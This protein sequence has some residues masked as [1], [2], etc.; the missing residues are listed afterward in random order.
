M[1]FVVK[2]CRVYAACGVLQTPNY[3]Y[4]WEVHMKRKSQKFRRFI[5]SAN[6]VNYRENAVIIDHF[7][8]SI[9]LFKRFQDIV[10]AGD[11]EL[12]AEKLRNAGT[13]L[14]QTCEW[15][16]KNYLH[17]RYVELGSD[18]TLNAEQKTQKIDAL[19]KKD[20]T[21][22][23][24]IEEFKKISKPSYK[25]CGINFNDILG[26]AQLTNN[27]P[28]HN[29]TIPDPNKYIKS[30][31]EVRKIISNYIDGDAKL[32]LI[33][34]SIYGEGNAWYEVLEYTSDFSDAYSY[35]LVTRSIENIDVKG[36]FSLKWDLILDLDPA[37]DISGLE[38]MYVDN[39]GATPWIRILDKIDS[40]K[41]FSMS[42][43]P[44]WIMG[45]GSVDN[46][47][48]IAEESKWR[49]RYGKYLNGVLEEFHKIYTK[50]VKVFV[51]PMSNERN[52][53]RIVECFDDIYDEGETVDFCV[54]SSQ[55]EYSRIDN[56]NFKISS[57]SFEEFCNN[58]RIFFENDIYLHGMINHQL[59]GEAGKL[60]DIPDAFDM[61]LQDSFEV[62]YINVETTEEN[63]V[64][65]TVKSYFYRGDCDISWY[66]LKNGFDVIR[67]EQ[68]SIIEKINRD[69][70]DRGRYLKRICYEPGV[71]GTTLMRRLAWELRAQYPTL[72][73]KKYNEQ[74]ARNIQKLYDITHGQILIFADSNNIEIEEIK[75]LQFELKRMGFAF[76][77]CYM[78]RKL[79]GLPVSDAAIYTI[80]KSFI[81]PEAIE[82]K[83]R[84]IEYTSDVDVKSKLNDII[85]KNNSDERIPFIMS[86]YTFDKEFKGIKPYIS[87]YLTHM[88]NYLKKMV[89][90]LALA[91]YGN[92]SIDMQYFMDLFEDDNTADFIV[93]KIPGINELIRIE[94]INGKDSIRIRYHLFAEEILK[95]MSL[96]R[97]ANAISFLNLVD[98]ILEFIEDSRKNKFN[99]NQDT[100]RL[101]RTLF[102]TRSA[103][104]DAEKPAFSPLITK[105][106]E[107]HRTVHNGQ[108]SEE[109]DA[110]IRIFNKLVEVYPEEA[111]FTAHLAR[112]YFY[113]DRN[114]KKGFDNINYAIKLSD[115]MY[116]YVD[117]LLFH[118]KAMGYSSKICNEYIHKVMENCRQGNKEENCKLLI[119]IEEDATKAFE[120]FKKVRQSNIGIA[121]HVSEINLCISIAKMA[122]DVLE[123]TENFEQYILSDTGKWVMRYIDKATCL[124]EE[125]RKIAPET[126]DNNLEEIETKI[127]DLKVGLEESISLWEDY[128]KQCNGN[129]KLQAR[130]LL[131]G[132]YNKQSKKNISYEEKQKC[133]TRIIELMEDNMTEENNHSGNI[134]IWFDTIRKCDVG[135][136]DTLL[137]DAIIKLN[138]WIA[139]TDSVEAHYYRFIL[140]FIQA[141]NGSA[142]AESELP[143]L[144]RELKAKSLNL[145]NRTATQ[146]WLMSEGEG[147]GKLMNNSRNKKEALSEEEMAEKM[148]LLV[149]RISNNYVNDSH[150]Y[151][152]FRGV[153]VYFNP[154]ATKGEIDRTKINQRVRFGIGFSYDGP[155]AFNSSIKL[156]G[157]DDYEEIER[158]IEPGLVVKCE[159]IKNVVYFT[160]VRII[161]YNSHIGSIHISELIA[162]YSNT[163][164]PKIGDII[165]AKVLNEKFD[166]R[167]QR[168]VWM[169]TMDMSNSRIETEENETVMAKAIKNLNLDLNCK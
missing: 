24:L 84:L 124:W 94:N 73:L 39:V 81:K 120:L 91:D 52:L 115:T 33:D 47:D 137:M 168:N 132:V 70:K 43:L 28:K 125:V 16:L 105:L 36:L 144:L 126:N 86:M 9:S 40:K 10:A 63:D 109:N 114:F 92:T 148:L 142:L 88:N 32:D 117:P 7:N 65:K 26:N 163:N 17:R 53:E 14:Y 59:P 146:H 113:I 11:E 169:L 143:K 101:L 5:T 102:I 85:K 111:H 152:K 71:G 4:I 38:K 162:P 56:E 2:K 108:Y 158:K 6:A 49:N 90:A 119:Q 67:K 159:V 167:L 93:D 19:S 99:I 54:L 127:R 150:A 37:S 134:R 45:N 160:Q 83:S 151:I 104:V 27:S 147:I 68:A 69:M 74:T 149:G 95:Q 3:Y 164:R 42:R 30:V 18:G 112:Y 41:K 46:P 107:E 157:N 130:R 89:F 25:L 153:E 139:L 76:L 50:P 145:Y 20:A 156:L 44:Y 57:L 138:K 106:I 58:M 87:N 13:C 110:I 66:G 118:M 131:A 96:G 161:G 121:G 60:F 22:Y 12:A 29:A 141:I 122:R 154:S 116:G 135:N 79:K 75:N 51:Y 100:L 77:I 140:K 103:D 97:E 15:S 61:E 129:S 31:G 35:V 8:N 34:D 64:I 123:E 166:N 23:N 1:F 82:M 62:V 21:L 80:V 133:Y 78:E 55:G 165:D 155:R 72:I 48:S 98:P 128:L 136:Q